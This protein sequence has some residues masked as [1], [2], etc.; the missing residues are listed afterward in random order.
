MHENIITIQNVSAFHAFALNLQQK[1]ARRSP[2]LREVNHVF[3]VFLRQQRLARGN[4][5][6]NRYA[7]SGRARRRWN[8]KG[9]RL[10]SLLLENPFPLQRGNVVLNRRRRN[11]DMT[12]NLPHRWRETVAV[13]VFVNEIQNGLLSLGEHAKAY[14]VHLYGMSMGFVNP[15]NL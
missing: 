2:I 9:A 13:D 12:A 15:R 6:D 7:G 10:E 1:G 4:L 3:D 11:S 8:G 14:T 5:S